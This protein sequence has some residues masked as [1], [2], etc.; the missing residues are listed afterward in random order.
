MAKHKYLPPHLLIIPGYWSVRI[1]N[2]L[3]IILWFS[4][5]RILVALYC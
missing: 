3:K 2:V 4:L 1:M 5:L